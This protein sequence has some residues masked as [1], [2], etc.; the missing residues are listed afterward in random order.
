MVAQVTQ[1][2]QVF[3]KRDAANRNLAMDIRGGRQIDQQD[4]MA[5]MGCERDRWESLLFELGAPCLQD[6]LLLKSHYHKSFLQ[7]NILRFCIR[8]HDLAVR[9][10]DGI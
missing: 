4:P 1:P 2:R 6:F 5:V 9:Q 10:H 7:S 8:H 3:R